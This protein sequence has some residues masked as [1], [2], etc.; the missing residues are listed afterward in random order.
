MGVGGEKS[1]GWF[2]DW[3]EGGIECVMETTRDGADAAVQRRV[4]Y[5]TYI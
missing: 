2:R 1:E 5:I 4:I 3:E